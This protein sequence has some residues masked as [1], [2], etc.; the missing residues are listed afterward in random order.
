M[1]PDMGFPAT[2]TPVEG[3]TAVLRA[4]GAWAPPALPA[5]AAATATASS[6]SSGYGARRWR[7]GGRGAEFDAEPVGLGRRDLVVGGEELPGD[8]VV[9]GGVAGE[10]GLGR[11]VG[12]AI[13]RVV[14]VP[15]VM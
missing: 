4:A 6:S 11:V 13:G 15:H 10:G 12:G 14:E 5:S 1:V 2:G 7:R 8:E 9:G 3:H